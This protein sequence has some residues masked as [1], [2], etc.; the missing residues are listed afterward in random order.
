MNIKKEHSKALFT[1]L[2]PLV[3]LILLFGFYLLD[4]DMRWLAVILIGVIMMAIFQQVPEK[5]ILLLYLATFFLPYTGGGLYSHLVHND[6]IF[7]F[8]VFLFLM[9]GVWFAKTNGFQKSPLY[10]HKTTVLGILMIFWAMLAIPFC[11]SRAGALIGVF[12]LTKSFLFYFYL[13][14]RLK[15]KRQLK[16]VVN[17]LILGMAIQGFLGLMQKVVGHGLGLS[18][19]GEKILNYG[20]DISRV[21]GT[22]GA[23]NQYGAYIILIMPLAISFY[24]TTKKRI[25][26]IKYTVILLVTMAGLFFSLSRSSWFGLIGSLIV[27][28]SILYKQKQ[29]SPKLLK[30]ILGVAVLLTVF[31]IVFWDIIVLRFETGEKG[32]YRMI[33]IELAFPIIMSHP[34]FGVGLFNYQYHSFSSFEFW[35]P[36]HNTILRVA[37]EYGIPGLIF[38]ISFVVLIFKESF[39]NLRLKDQYMRTVA[40]GIIAG[41]TAFAIAVQFGPEY[42]HYRQKT[43]FWILAGLTI[44]LKRIAKNESMMGKKMA[45]M[46][47]R[48]SSQAIGEVVPTHNVSGGNDKPIGQKSINE[49]VFHQRL[50][51]RG[52][53]L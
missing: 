49:K 5:E 29:L 19:W 47:R 18:F 40:M 8:D 4:L 27:I 46:R 26:K 52:G 14:N 43:I 1:I 30:G 45:M 32:Q 6:L 23:P 2:V 16:I 37:A 20:S 13:I 3:G 36:V 44:S 24:I 11:I 10:F 22:L 12:M 50:N 39:R 25:E 34:I 41:Y 9:I 31:A 7:A 21:R 35:H 42:Q 38:F 15:T 51:G 53:N 28:L 33:M 48:K 17:M